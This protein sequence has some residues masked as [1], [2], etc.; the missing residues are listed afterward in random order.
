MVPAA[1]QDQQE[2]VA[3]NHAGPDPIVGSPPIRRR[4]RV[5]TRHHPR[6]HRPGLLEQ[7]SEGASKFLHGAIRRSRE[8]QDLHVIARFNAA[9]SSSGS[10]VPIRKIRPE[11]KDSSTASK[12]ET[13]QSQPPG[14]Q[15]IPQP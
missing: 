9:V 3:Q 2:A 14:T 15:R 6:N 11:V 4:S 12:P 7:H 5:A 8:S 1:T 13:F 10:S